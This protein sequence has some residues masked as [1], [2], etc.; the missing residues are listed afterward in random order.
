M[1]YFLQGFGVFLGVLAGVVVTYFAQWVG[2]RFEN[3][4]KLKNLKFEINLNLIKIDSWLEKIVKYRNAV[5]G[6]A[7]R[8]FFEYFDLSRFISITANKMF[9]EGLL[10][11][12]WSEE[13]IGELLIIYSEFSL[14]GERFLNN[15]VNQDRTNFIT[16]QDKGDLK[17]LAAAKAIAVQNVDFWENKL[18]KHK[19]TLQGAL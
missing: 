13:T 19:R 12:Y 15:L 1:N 16:A 17:G 8:S 14:D 2:A 7:L 4:Q 10:Y 11:K 3:K 6:D 9:S 5:N 18:K